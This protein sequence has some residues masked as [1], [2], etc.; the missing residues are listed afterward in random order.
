[1]E[2][3]TSG[4]RHRNPTLLRRRLGGELRR[5]R[6]EARLTTDYVAGR[7]Y[8][9]ASKIS[10]L[11]TGRVRASLR[12][13]RDLLELYEVAGK[14]ASDLIE[15]AHEARH[16]DAWWHSCRDVPDVRT[17]V[18]Y[19]RA[20]DSIC[21]YESLVIPG[22]LQVESYAY[23]ITR[24]FFPGLSRQATARHVELRL[25]RQRLLVAEDAPTL[26]V[27]LDEAALRRMLGMSEVISDQLE[28]LMSASNLP[29][30][31][32][33]VLPFEVGAHA[34]MTGPFTILGFP[35]DDDRDIV[36]S[37]FPNGELYFDTVEDIT[38]YK[39]L[40]KQLQSKALD[41]TQTL[42]FLEELGGTTRRSLPRQQTQRTRD[43]IL[44]SERP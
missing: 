17:F 8:C 3:D 27:V 40:F 4:S 23:L 37:E 20:T 35:H 10:R 19:E 43:R 24:T 2:P 12:D 29:N 42:R 39:Q 15:L 18:S 6:E 16:R 11:E 14:Q 30:V 34:G 13:V 33:Q 32:F 25:D 7:L 44:D 1:M 41:P 21:G 28:H 5:L 38:R 22:L 9:S 26:S 31:V 36:F